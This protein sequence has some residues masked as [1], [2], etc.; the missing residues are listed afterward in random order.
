MNPC[1]PRRRAAFTLFE[2]LIAI[3]IF[4][5]LA[6]GIFSSVRAAFIA[7]AQVVDNQL[8]GERFTAFQQFLRKMFVSLPPDARVELRQREMAG[9]GD[10]VELRVWPAPEFLRFGRDPGDGA[11]IS[12]QPD[13]R[14]GFRMMLGFFRAKDN[15]DEREEWLRRTQWLTL[16]PGIEQLRWRFAPTRNPV[17]EEKWTEQSGRPGLVELTLK[18]E[19]G[20]ETVSQFWVPPL[21]RRISAPTEVNQQGPGQPPAQ[22]PSGEEA[23]G[24]GGDAAE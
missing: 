8:D 21:Q 9:L 4:V 20:G 14:G 23:G 3:A 24:E 17:F 2:V 18:M 12:A 10:V 5:L 6:G 13:G 19:N 16:L 11:A 15:A 7:S 22:P 1:P